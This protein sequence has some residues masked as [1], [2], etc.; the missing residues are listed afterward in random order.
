[1]PDLAVSIIA[2]ALRVSPGSQVS[3][4]VEVRNLGSVVDRYTC[5]IVGIDAG[6][7]SVTPA[8]VELFPER[9]QPADG[10]A[11]ADAPPTIGRFTVTIRPP[12]TPEARA[13]SWPIGAKV[14]SEHDPASRVV[15]ETVVE[16]L[17]FGLLE[18]DLIPSQL[19]GRLRGIAALSLRNAGN[20]PETF[21]PSASDKA[22][23]LSYEFMPEAVTLQGGEDQPIQLKVSPSKLILLGQ[24]AT[25]PFSVEV[26]G[27][28]PGT[29][30]VTIQGSLHQGSIIP[31]WLPRAVTTAL[32][33]AMAAFALWKAFL[34]PQVNESIKQ[35][36]APVASQVAAIQSSLPSG[37]PQEQT[38]P[39]ESAAPS[40]SGSPGGPTPTPTATPITSLPPGTS[41][42]AQ[43]FSG[44]FGTTDGTSVQT[45]NVPT[46][47]TFTLTDVFLS[48][49][50]GDG[51]VIRFFRGTEPLFEWNA[52][53]F[54]TLDDHFVTGIK[55][56]GSQDVRV[57]WSCQPN[58]F[59]SPAAGV[60]CRTN[61]VL[62]GTLAK[63]K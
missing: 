38:G 54:R 29:P 42:V 44:T 16:V 10:R 30:E 31:A 61:I 52:S 59:A 18:A 62:S 34:E 21:E 11:R 47:F 36:I 25:R 63:S 48:N 45:F 23:F 32:L 3:F 46:G 17:P 12:R 13:G 14:Q 6:W 56:T 40:A 39:P 57:Q 49:T 43:S 28:G 15:E 8:A 4:V 26:R 22:K 20:R 50:G 35:A 7:W 53:D 24:P 2:D 60:S 5:E 9:D 37:G 1:V 41:S 33:L 27:D 58:P 55:V 51:G 19:E